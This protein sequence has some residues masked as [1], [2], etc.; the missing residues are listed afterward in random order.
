MTG[1]DKTRDL[2]GIVCLLAII[3]G[4]SEE[5]DNTYAI[6][7]EYF[8]TKFDNRTRVNEEQRTTS[9]TV[10]VSSTKISGEGETESVDLASGRFVDNQIRF[11]GEIEKSTR[12]LISVHEGEEEVSTTSALV[13]PSEEVAFA[14]ER[15]VGLGSDSL[16][17]DLLGAARRSENP[18]TKFAI[19]GDFREL[20]ENLHLASVYV[21]RKKHPDVEFKT[22]VRPSVKINDIF[23]NDKRAEYFFKHGLLTV[24]GGDISTSD[25][26]YRMRIIAKGV[27]DRTLDLAISTR[28]SII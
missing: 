15:F 12:V 6:T 21:Q 13:L 10:I 14:Y 17:V 8:L 23:L 7:G 27:P 26:I 3:A 1:I 19:K 20:N 4:C 2:I 18:A 11:E 16:T 9:A 25:E 5:S 24:E 22:L 28:R